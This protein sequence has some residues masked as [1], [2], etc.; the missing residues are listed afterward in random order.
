MK[1]SLV[2]TQTGLSL[3]ELMIAIT[4]GLILM[5][6][7]V[8]MF[9]GSR[10]TFVTQQSISR[11]QETGRLAIEFLSQ[12]VRMAG[13][14]GCASR[15]AG[16][17]LT[18]V[19]NSTGYLY[20]FNAV[21]GF[22]SGPS[23]VVPSGSGISQTPVANTD[24]LGLS[25]MSTAEGE[26]YLSKEN[27]ADKIFVK[28]TSTVLD[29]CGEGVTKYN[30][31]CPNDILVIS[32]CESIRIFQAT[33]FSVSGTD[34][35]IKHEEAG[36]PG[37][38]VG[39]WTIANPYELFEEGA[40]VQKISKV[41]YFVANSS[42]T[43][44]PGL[45]QSV[46]GQDTELLEGVEDFSVSYGVDTIVNNEAVADTYM[47]AGDV[48]TANKWGSVLSVRIRMLVASAEDNVLEESKPI[49]FNGVEKVITDKRM[50][51]IFVST[52]GLRNRM[53]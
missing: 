2:Q 25:V 44:R 6:G 37:N 7:V 42:V 4:L 11:V 33:D 5:T 23:S 30:G 28:L 16:S 9:A 47:S 38:T 51:Q 27:S 53:E 50:R 36:S 20:N 45:W 40:S 17:N 39:D 10:T 12:D 8:Q 32:D 15:A 35:E 19:V 14:A 3:V 18:S 31:F 48:T 41:T 43:G 13:F 49:T 24:I 21:Q 29:G 46:D 34:L 52:V 26:S 22:N 1:K